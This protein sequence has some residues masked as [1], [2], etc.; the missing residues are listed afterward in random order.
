MVWCR[1]EGPAVVHKFPDNTS[2]RL[3]ASYWPLMFALM[4]LGLMLCLKSKS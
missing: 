3:Q 4:I 2:N 1:G